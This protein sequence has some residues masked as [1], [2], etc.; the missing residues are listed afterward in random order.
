[1]KPCDMCAR[2]ETE[3]ALKSLLRKAEGQKG[4]T[5]IPVSSCGSGLFIYLF[6][7]FYYYYLP[8]KA[9]FN[10]RGPAHVFTKQIMMSDENRMK[11]H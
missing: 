3:R 8:P 9:G 2:E 4:F 11:M 6:I 1:M 7:Y 5:F 10:W